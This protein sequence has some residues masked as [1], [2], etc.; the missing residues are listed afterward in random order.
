MDL[1]NSPGELLD[2]PELAFESEKVVIAAGILETDR[3]IKTEILGQIV[4]DHFHDGDY[5]IIASNMIALWSRTGA[6]DLTL[7]VG[8]LKQAGIAQP[9]LVIAKAARTDADT[10]NWREHLTRVNEAHER[11]EKF[12]A[13][14]KLLYAIKFSEPLEHHLAV[15]LRTEADNQNHDS[16]QADDDPPEPMA[17]SAFHGLAGEIV[18][19]IEP[20]TEACREGLLMQLLAAFGS[21]IN[22]TA[23][24]CAEADEHYCNQFLCLVGDTSKG[25]K[26][27]SWGQIRRLFRMVDEP[28][29]DTRCPTGLSSGEGLIHQVR[30]AIYKPDKKGDLVMVDEGIDDKRL[31]VIES[32][33]GG[34]LRSIAREKNT[35]SAV[36]R[37]AWDSKPIL[38][39]LTKNSPTKATAAHIAIVG[40]ITR[41]ELR[42]LLSNCDIANGLANRFLWCRVYRS[43][44]LPEGGTLET[45]SLAVMAN[46]LERSIEFA[47]GRGEVRR[48]QQA[49]E[50]WHHVY[51]SLSNGRPGAWG[52]A[53]GRAEAQVMRLAVVLAMICRSP[54][55]TREILTAALAIWDYCDQ[56]ARYVFGFSTGSRTADR[57]INEL[58]QRQGMTRSEIYGI[59]KGRVPAAE[60]NRC[61]GT[62]EG[63]GLATKLS[64]PTS[65]RP[66]ECWRAA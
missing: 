66:Q 17:V 37:D 56:S 7:L 39:T 62:L 33:F 16:R 25:R 24:F 43:K 38:Q 34:T 10:H 12:F 48:D 23:H 3:A 18:Y 1:A 53:T 40:H 42:E 65:G 52:M 28:F 58:R 60:L 59:F 45:E 19:E 15:I 6:L 55:I 9:E 57:I 32:E 2:P 64:V 13:A 49:R 50:L 4:A 51:P 30:D 20:H 63:M 61:M 14:K 5:R 29:A 41:T 47:R 54:I 35:L 8:E 36:M 27:T 22:R 31:L 26:G 11:F 46:S 44:F 21:C